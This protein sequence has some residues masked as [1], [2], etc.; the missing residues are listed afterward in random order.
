MFDVWKE[1]CD[2]MFKCNILKLCLF[3]MFILI[4]FKLRDDA[5]AQKALGFK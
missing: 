2:I 5:H 4:V 1:H 3:F